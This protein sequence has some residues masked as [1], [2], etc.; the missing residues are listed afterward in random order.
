MMCTLRG[1]IE[2]E[3]KIT[4]NVMISRLTVLP[5]EVQ[6]IYWS[7]H[8]IWNPIVQSTAMC[9]RRCSLWLSSSLF[10][11]TPFSLIS[12]TLEDEAS[13][14]IMTGILNCKTYQRRRSRYIHQDIYQE[15][16]KKMCVHVGALKELGND[17]KILAKMLWIRSNIPHRC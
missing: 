7:S 4:G 1:S 12:H 13:D 2:I 14:Q 10:L 11:V 3:Q 8:V 16:I 15:A 17:N 9:H 5:V 6:L